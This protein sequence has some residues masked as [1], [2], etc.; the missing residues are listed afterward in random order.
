M[1]LLIWRDH[2]LTNSLHLGNFL[3]GWYYFE[4]S[5]VKK[6]FWYLALSPWL[7]QVYMCLVWWMKLVFNI[8]WPQLSHQ[9]T[10]FSPP[11]FTAPRP[12]SPTS[13][14]LLGSL[15]C[16]FRYVSS[17]CNYILKLLLD[18]YQINDVFD[19]LTCSLT[20]R[21]DCVHRNEILYCWYDPSW[22]FH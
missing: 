3:P 1:L 4:I 22:L 21:I 8:T 18:N 9:S 15:K 19:N 6:T 13:S 11:L 14:P 10:H 2:I 5:C 7:F 16:Y 20:S 12:K 17:F